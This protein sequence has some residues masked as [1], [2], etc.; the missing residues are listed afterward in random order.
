MPRSKITQNKNQIVDV[1][2]VTM[3]IILK[4]HKKCKL[5][6]KQCMQDHTLIKFMHN[7]NVKNK[8]LKCGRHVIIMPYFM[9]IQKNSDITT[10]IL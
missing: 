10:H 3:S 6:V 9:T 4:A 8:L 7:N 2:Y 1:H 5:K